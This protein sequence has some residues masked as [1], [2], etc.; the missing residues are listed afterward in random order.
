MN[1]NNALL[2]IL[3]V[4]GLGVSMPFLSALFW[5]SAIVYGFTGKFG[6]PKTRMVGSAA[7]LADMFFIIAIGFG[8]F[9]WTII[10]YAVILANLFFIAAIAWA[11]TI[12]DDNLE[13]WRWSLREE[14]IE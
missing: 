1:L 8:I 12:L 14:E 6:N 11:S 9:N 2:I 13:S 7:L 4:A 5:A 10:G 3:G